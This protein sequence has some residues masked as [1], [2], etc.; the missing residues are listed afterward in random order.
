M[1]FSSY[2]FLFAFLPLTLL[3]YV[4]C[5][6][7]LRNWVALGTSLFFYAW[8]APKF[9][10]V[11]IGGCAVDFALGRWLPPGAAPRRR[12]AALVVSLGLNVATLAWFKYANFAVESVNALLAAAGWGAVAWTQVALPIGISFFTF[13]RMS[14][15][16]DV[17]RGLTAPARGFHDYLLYVVLF[18][19]LVAG[20]IVRYHDVAEQIRGRIH[21][22]GRF[23]DG[24]WRFGL[25]LGKKVLVANVMGAVADRVFAMPAA[26]LPA[27]VAWAGVVCYAFQ[28]YFD[29]SGYSDMA[30]GLGRM[31]GFEFLENFDRPYTSRTITEFWR[32]WHISLSNWMREYLYV[33]LGGNRVGPVRGMANLWIVFLVSG[34]WHGAAWNFVVWGA[35]HGLWLSLEK[36]AGRERLGRVPR[37]IGVPATFVLVCVS[38]VLF[39]AESLAAA[40]RYLACMFDVRRL[41]LVPPPVAWPEL[42]PHEAC[43]VLAV[44]AAVCFVPAAFPAWTARLDARAAQAGPALRA[45]RFAAAMLLLFLSTAAIVASDFNPFIY[46]RF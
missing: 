25:G 8:G 15:L 46:F 12:R 2:T 27:S 3:A 11:L 24:I 20:P 35:Y 29:F 34:L 40:G 13:Q 16:V 23:L 9:V 10:F 30:I 5:P 6:P 21:D 28:I 19:Q 22:P 4:L 18:P 37:W 36:I 31:L 7:R 45:L 41:G 42:L 44:A 17:H 26:G 43:A 38:W 39:R 14:Y 33:P 1:V 32:R